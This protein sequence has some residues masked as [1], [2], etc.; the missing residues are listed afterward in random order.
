[1]KQ[2]LLPLLM[3]GAITADIPAQLS[4]G[5]APEIEA[6]SWMNNPPGTSLEDLRGRVV[7][8]EFWATW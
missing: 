3:V 6:K 4:Q 8:L 2:F 1:M 5:W 7:F